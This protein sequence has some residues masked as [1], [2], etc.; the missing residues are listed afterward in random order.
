L[1]SLLVI[2][3]FRAMP[4]PVLVDAAR[5]TGTDMVK[6]PGEPATA[7]QERHRLGEVGAKF[8]STASVCAIALECSR[9]RLGGLQGRHPPR[10]PAY[11]ASRLT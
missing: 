2:L 7:V 11:R 3:N 5:N 10:H 4:G 9:S 8:S 6:A 1:E